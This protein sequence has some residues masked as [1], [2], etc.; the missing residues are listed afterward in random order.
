EIDSYLI[1]YGTD[2]SNLA[3]SVV[4]GSGSDTSAQI[5]DMVAGTYYFVILTIDIDGVQSEES[6][7]ISLTI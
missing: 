5:D 4:V 7:I 2:A 1:R 6:E 3:Q